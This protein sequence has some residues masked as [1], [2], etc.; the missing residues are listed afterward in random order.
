MHEGSLAEIEA[1][2]NAEIEKR[3]AAYDRGEIVALDAEEVFAR[4]RRV[5]RGG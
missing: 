4:A 5:A 2:W 3:L 1:A